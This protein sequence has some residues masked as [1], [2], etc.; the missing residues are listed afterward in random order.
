MTMVDDEKLFAWLDGELT[1]DEGEAMA[2][3]VVADP[4]LSELA[5]RHRALAGRLKSA[6]DTVAEAPMPEGLSNAIRGSRHQVID[7]GTVARSKAGW[8]PVPQWLALAAT[9]VLGVGMGT[10]VRQPSGSPVQ[11]QDGRIY[12]AA[13]L[14][15]ALDTQLASAPGKGDIR[16]GL[17]FRDAKGSVCRSF[18]GS[19]ASGLACRHGDQWQLRGIFAAPEGQ[20]DTYRMAAGMNPNLAA[21]VDSTIAG[22]P[23]DAAKEKA[24]RDRGWR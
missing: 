3:K 23:F 20:S 13:S 12:A 6:F 22:E 1:G 8:L 14:G 11:L 15:Q 4:R 19:A 7:F 24:A 10:L 2:A 17:T 16:V 18:S 5:E 21:L 9:L